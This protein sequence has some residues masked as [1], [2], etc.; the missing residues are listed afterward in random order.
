M[1]DVPDFLC[2][3][4]GARC[5]RAQ[6]PSC[7][8]CGKYKKWANF[9]FCLLVLSVQR[10]SLPE[11]QL[12]TRQQRVRFHQVP[13]RLPSRN[14]LP[15]VF[16]FC[17]NAVRDRSHRR[18][19]QSQESML[20]PLTAPGSECKAR[21]SPASRPAPD[22]AQSLAC[23]A[24]AQPGEQ[25]GRDRGT[26]GTSSQLHMLCTIHVL[27]GAELASWASPDLPE[28]EVKVSHRG[29][30]V[31]P[32]MTS[33]EKPGGQDSG[34]L[35]GLAASV[36]VTAVTSERCAH[37]PWG[38]GE[39]ALTSGLSGT[40]ACAPLPLAPPVLPWRTCRGG[41]AVEDAS[42]KAGHSPAR[43]HKAGRRSHGP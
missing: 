35:P 31:S 18:E 41:P 3:T 36:H 4:S 24:C 23:W 5:P 7:P 2:C 16:T 15:A 32:R 37:D 34:G 40:P 29:S 13:C 39:R 22:S 42:L 1:S 26:V 25:H 20:R 28:L 38:E 6:E 8:F 43:G 27:S 30:P 11:D 9:H 10:P 19:A 14:D 21:A 33:D 17:R 12:H